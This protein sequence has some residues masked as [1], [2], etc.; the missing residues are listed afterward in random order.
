M[1][2]TRVGPYIERHS[3]GAQVSAQRTAAGWRFCAWSAPALPQISF[4]DWHAQ[5]CD[6]VT[7][8]PGDRTPQR[9]ECLGVRET[10]EGARALA[11]RATQST[12][13]VEAEGNQP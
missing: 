3:S 9:V 6:R 5:H 12:T 7:R 10:A 11:E 8:A 1:S 4:W 2:W 13:A